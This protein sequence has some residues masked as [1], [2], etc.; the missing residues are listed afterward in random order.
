M[1]EEQQRMMQ[2]QEESSMQQQSFSSSSVQKQQQQQ[3]SSSS[4]S[5]MRQEQSSSSS[6]MR[7]E[8]SSSMQ[9]QQ[10][11]KMTKKVHQVRWILVAFNLKSFDRSEL[12]L[13]LFVL[14]VTETASSLG[15]SEEEFKQHSRMKR[16][17]AEAQEEV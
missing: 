5:S 4:S 8:Q 14:Q 12:Y 2:Q 13:S 7:Q 6:S 15:M 9:M 16:L 17:E 3:T 1:Y 11:T 10:E